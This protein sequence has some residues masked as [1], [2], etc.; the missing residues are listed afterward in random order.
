MGFSSSPFFNRKGAANGSQQVSID[1]TPS[2]P[3]NKCGQGRRKPGKSRSDDGCVAEI[4]ENYGSKSRCLNVFKMTRGAYIDTYVHF[5]RGFPRLDGYEYI[6]GH[7]RIFCHYLRFAVT[8]S[9][10]SSR[11]SF[12]SRT[13]WGQNVRGYSERSS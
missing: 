6:Q 4:L 10:R 9:V 8:H 3:H 11:I 7:V 12:S 1:K 2:C 5:I 13:L